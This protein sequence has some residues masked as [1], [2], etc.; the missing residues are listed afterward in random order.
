MKDKL[1]KIKVLFK[2]YIYFGFKEWK[3]EVWKADLDD[4]ACCDGH[5]CC[6]N[7]E[8]NRENFER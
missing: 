2:R 8:T 7:G 3:E 5:M 1:L 6:C 4:M